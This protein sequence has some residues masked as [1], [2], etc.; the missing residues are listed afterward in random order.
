MIFLSS[1][2]SFDMY[3]L[4]YSTPAFLFWTHFKC[5]ALLAS[6]TSPMTIPA[7]AANITT[8]NADSNRNNARQSGSQRQQRPAP[9]FRS[10]ADDAGATGQDSGL[11]L[12]LRRKRLCPEAGHIATTGSSMSAHFNLLSP[13]PVAAPGEE[14]EGNRVRR[15]PQFSSC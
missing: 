9:S 11:P 10:G 15:A 5:W 3:G 6:P 12:R 4:R 8:K 13:T 1:T 7:A 2:G 14:E